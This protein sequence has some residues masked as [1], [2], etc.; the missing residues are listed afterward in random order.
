EERPEDER[1]DAEQ[2]GRRRREPVVRGETLLDRVEGRGADVAVDDAE[3]GERQR[4]SLAPAWAGRVPRFARG[5]PGR[6][7]PGL[8]PDGNDSQQ[9]PTA[10]APWRW[11]S[12]GGRSAR[13]FGGVTP[14]P[15]AHRTGWA[16]GF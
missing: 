6:R 12:D 5:P 16:T 9:D 14:K 13:R 7:I 3:G 2:V 1:Q 8:P 11:P 15:V 10:W 4:C